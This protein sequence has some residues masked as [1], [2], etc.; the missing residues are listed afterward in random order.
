MG[1]GLALVHKYRCPTTLLLTPGGPYARSPQTKQESKSKEDLSG[2]E[3]ERIR[4]VS[5]SKRRYHHLVL[6]ERHPGLGPKAERQAWPLAQI[7]RPGY[8]DRPHRAARLP[9]PSPASRRLR[10]LTSGADGPRAPNT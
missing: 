3:L 2:Q 7:F 4:Q 9:S 6:S 5:Q 1:N 8:G 10:P